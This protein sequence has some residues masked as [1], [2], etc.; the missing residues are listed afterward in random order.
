MNIMYSVK[1]IDTVKTTDIVDTVK[2]VP[3]IDNDPE[4]VEEVEETPSL[5]GNKTSSTK[6]L[7]FFSSKLVESK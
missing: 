2:D 4:E 3:L 6:I 1:S 7:K 5:V